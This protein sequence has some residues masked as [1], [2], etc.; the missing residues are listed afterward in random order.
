MITRNIFWPNVLP[1]IKGTYP[2]WESIGPGGTWLDPVRESMRSLWTWLQ[3]FP[4]KSPEYLNG[5]RVM[6]WGALSAA[7]AY[8]IG[9]LG[10]KA[11]GIIAGAVGGTVF[12]SFLVYKSHTGDIGIYLP[13]IGTVAFVIGP[14]LFA[15]LRWGKM[16]GFNMDKLLHRGKYSEEGEHKIVSEKV[17]RWRKRFGMGPEFTRGDRFIFI[18]KTCLTF[19]WWTIFLTGTIIGVFWTIPDHIWCKYWLFNSCLIMV[20]GIIYTVWFLIG[21]TSNLIDLFH[22]LSRIKRDALDDGRVRT[23]EEELTARATLEQQEEQKP[24]DAT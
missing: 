12:I 23:E 22:R 4:E 16:E 3:H 8:V 5:N 14:Y 1:A 7:S 6:F 11:R 2:I 19:F 21:G 10:L 13:V 24:P 9:S 15:M 20:L 18:F 17:S